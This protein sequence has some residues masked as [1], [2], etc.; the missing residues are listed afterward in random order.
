MR[1][2]S[3]LHVLV[4]VQLSLKSLMPQV[5]TAVFLS[6]I[7]SLEVVCIMFFGVLGVYV[8]FPF[9]SCI[10][11]VHNYPSRVWQVV[12]FAVVSI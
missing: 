5:D 10:K 7:L 1:W 11:L 9:L 6:I 2:S 8:F 12:E 4:Q 3:K